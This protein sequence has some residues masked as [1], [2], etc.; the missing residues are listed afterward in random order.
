MCSIF[1]LF[2]DSKLVFC[3]RSTFERWWMMKCDVT[4]IQLAAQNSFKWQS[5]LDQFFLFC[6]FVSSFPLFLSLLAPLIYL[7]NISMILCYIPANDCMSV[8]CWRHLVADAIGLWPIILE[9]IYAAKKEITSLARTHSNRTASM[10]EI[11]LYCFALLLHSS[12]FHEKKN[13]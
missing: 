10:I 2:V 9:K 11:V 7:W 5:S 1:L 12:T 13:N 8:S 4:W 6:F 3:I